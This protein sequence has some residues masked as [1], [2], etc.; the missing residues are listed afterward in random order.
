MIFLAEDQ[1]VLDVQLHLQVHKAADATGREWLWFLLN[2]HTLFSVLVIVVIAKLDLLRFWSIKSAEIRIQVGTKQGRISTQHM[3]RCMPVHI[4]VF[5]LPISDAAL[6]Y[7]LIPA[8][9]CEK[10][11][12]FE[13]LG[14]NAPKPIFFPAIFLNT[15]SNL[16]RPNP[17]L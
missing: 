17:S 8:F 10:K 2:I 3:L 16:V 11:N 9:P 1:L 5:L 6:L 13:S 14:A 4:C 15:I 7:S 12:Y